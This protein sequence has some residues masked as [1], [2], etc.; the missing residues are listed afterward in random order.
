MAVINTG[1]HPKL[2]WPGVRAVFGQVYDEHQAEYPDLFDVAS[3]DMHYEED[4]ETTGFGLAPVKAEGAGVAY[5]SH[6]QGA[7]KRYTHLAYG[8]GYI[9][10]REERD[11]NL[12]ERVATNRARALAFSMAQT[13]ENVGALVYNNAFTTALSADGQ[14]IVDTDHNSLVGNQANEPSTPAALSEASLEDLAIQ[15]MNA[16]N[17]R[18]LQ[19]SLRPTRLIV[20]TA[21]GFEAER[22]L[23]S[24]QQ[25][26][27][28]NNDIN[29]LRSMSVIPTV[30]VNHYLTSTT[31]FFIRTNA[32][33]GMQ[34]FDRAPVE[35]A[36][37][38]DFDTDNIKHK[39]YMRFSAGCTDWRGLFAN[40]GA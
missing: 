34:W 14:A 33:N 15:I 11:D 20:P 1:S 28:A 25:S 21:L 19:I 17:S 7:V 39:A 12:Y 13:R 9:V 26:S 38:G 3:S 6:N 40:P 4:V 29:A 16:K 23:N 31:A 36:N 27:T 22:I 18:G 10:T 24:V 32:P 2:L 30:S 8:L 5:D 35:F 37:D